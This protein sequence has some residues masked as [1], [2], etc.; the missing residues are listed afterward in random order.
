MRNLRVTYWDH[1][2][3]FNRIFFDLGSFQYHDYSDGSC[4]AEISI[5]RYSAE[6]L[7]K[8]FKEAFTK[9]SSQ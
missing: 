2:V 4:S 3:D 1:L 6:E 5:D 8:A 7:R 9:G